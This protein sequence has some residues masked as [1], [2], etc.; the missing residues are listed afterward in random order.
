MNEIGTYERIQAAGLDEILHI[1]RLLGLARDDHGQVFALL[2][3]YIHC[4]RKTLF[5]AS[6]QGTSRQLKQKWALP[7]TTAV[8]Q[9]H[10]AGIVWG[11]AKPDKV[12]I[13]HNQDAW[14][15]DFG[16]GYTEGW[17]PRELR[18]SMRGDSKGLE[19]IIE[20]LS[21]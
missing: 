10:R 11:D 16:G 14:L 15:I 7:I 1:P 17:V 5:C 13:D 19:K 8:E 3:S 4:G 21:T 12:L 18:G 9:L 20:F 2:L 6:K